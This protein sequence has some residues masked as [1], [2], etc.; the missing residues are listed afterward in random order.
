LRGIERGAGR[1]I[2]QDG[3]VL[4][5]MVCVLAIIGLLAAVILPAI[6]RA[7]GRTGLQRYA[8]ATAALLEGDRV[9]ALRQRARVATLIDAE[10][11]TIRSGAGDR[12]V[13][14]PGDVR[15]DAMLP[16]HCYDRPTGMSIDFFPSGMSCGGVLAL[17]HGG[18]EYEIRV[19]WLTGAVDVLG[20]TAR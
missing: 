20:N 6:P 10:T 14:L 8:V 11:R 4:L 5:E 18:A 12:I 19:N 13:Q 17:T 1:S 3:Y 7:T 2:W 16:T 9:A 15:L